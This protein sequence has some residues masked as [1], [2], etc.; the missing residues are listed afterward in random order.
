[1]R[2]F[3]VCVLLLLLFSCTESE[4]ALSTDDT[5]QINPGDNGFVGVDLGSGNSNHSGYAMTAKIDGEDFLAYNPWGG[6]RYSSTNIWSFFSEEDY[7]MLQG[8][9]LFSIDQEINIWLKREDI[10]VGSYDIVESN[11]SGIGNIISHHIDYNNITNDLFE[12]T[13]GGT[14]EITEVDEVLKIVSGVFEVEILAEDY[15]VPSITI[16]ITNGTFR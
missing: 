14:I 9:E 12:S 7:V 2:N 16:N 8:R 15:G 6:N 4:I 5:I 10:V 3:C 13:V 1:M 11:L